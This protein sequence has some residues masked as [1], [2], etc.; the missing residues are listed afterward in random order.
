MLLPK[1]EN[2]RIQ[3]V[4]NDVLI[5]NQIIPPFYF[6]CCDGLVILPKKGRN[7]KTIVLDLNIEPYL[8]KKICQIY[9]PVSD[10]VCSHGHMD[11]IAHVHQWEALGTNIY[12]PI[13]ESSYLLDLSNFYRGFGFDKVL[14]FSIIKKFGNI[15][16]YKKSCN[17]CSFKP[18]DTLE[19]EDCIVDTIPLLGHS[20]SHIGFLLSQEKIIHISCLGFDQPKPGVEG[21]GPWYGFDECSIDQYLK[22]IDLSESIFL[23]HCKFLTSSHSYIV[24]HPDTT[25]FSYMRNK[26]EKNQ[27]IIDQAI[28]SLKNN[29]GSNLRI[30]NLLELDLFF[31]KKK[32]KS[33]LLEI[34][35]FWETGII[36]KHL[37]RSKYLN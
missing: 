34:Y 16:G 17:V 35:K 27:N 21:F 36:T 20:K 13:P 30:Q 25:P 31:P 24:N 18:G 7:S 22:D 28:L 2:L 9:G 26:I 37:E 33:F 32:M 6:S 11:H 23:K 29:N 8:I 3:K 15:N 5:V 14:N 10:Y 12:A 19:F 4:L 1:I